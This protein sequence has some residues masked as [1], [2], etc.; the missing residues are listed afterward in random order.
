MNLENRG[1]IEL[2]IAMA[3]SGT[4]GMFVLESGQPSYNAVFFR[5][6]FGGICLIVYCALKGYLNFLELTKKRW[7][8]IMS[9]GVAVVL[10]W[11]LLFESYKYASISI[12]TVAYQTQ[13]IFLV[14][15]ASIVLK[16]KFEAYNVVWIFLAF[17]GVVLIVDFYEPSVEKGQQLYGLFFALSAAVLYAVATLIIKQLDG[18]KPHFIAAIQV[19]L[20][21]ILLL[22][23]ANFNVAP[24]MV[25][26]WAWL[27]GL[28]VVHTSIMYILLYSSFQKVSTGS[29]AVLSYTY[30]GVAIL[31]DYLFY[32]QSLSWLQVLGIVLIVV[33]GFS[34][35]MSIN[36][37]NLIPLQ[38]RAR[39]S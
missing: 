26:G 3:L 13:P 7:L 14:L 30:P 24:S 12:S 6:L 18:V 10:N 22:P 2:I 9:S 36:V 29:I 15:L 32:D 38:K 25:E 5:C 37:F 11:V 4:I 1:K 33:A 27:V 17:I 34:N 31:I 16:E 23:F 8:L 21:C 20:G 39:E 19:S 35:N 28:G